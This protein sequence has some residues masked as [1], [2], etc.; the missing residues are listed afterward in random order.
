MGCVDWN[1]LAL[2]QLI[3]FSVASRM[4]CV[5][6]NRVSNEEIDPR[7]ASHPAWDAWIEIYNETLGYWSLT[8]A[9]RMGCVDWNFVVIIACLDTSFSRIPHGMRGLKY[10]RWKRDQENTPSHP[11]W[12]AWIEIA[13]RTSSCRLEQ[14]RIPHGMRGLKLLLLR[15]QSL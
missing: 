15:S 2:S 14:C 4:G 11:A 1:Q 3:T 12:D 6:W 8:V 5:D 10:H 9:S 13:M 7:F